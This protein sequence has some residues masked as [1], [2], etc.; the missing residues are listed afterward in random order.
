MRFSMA[1]P[2]TSRPAGAVAAR[3]SELLADPAGAAAMG[4]KGHAW[5]EREWTWDLVAERLQRILDG[6]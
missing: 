6:A 2:A 1:R 4:D 3:I 5:V